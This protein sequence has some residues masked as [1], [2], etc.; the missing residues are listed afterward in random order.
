MCKVEE[1]IQFFIGRQKESKQL[2]RLFTDTLEHGS[3]MVLIAGDTG[4]GKSSLLHQLEEN[5][6]AR[7]GYYLVCKSGPLGSSYPYHPLAELIRIFMQRVGQN[8]AKEIISRYSPR[9]L[10]E[11][12]LLVPKFARFL[13]NGFKAYSL[14]TENLPDKLFMENACSIVREM[15]QNTPVV[16]IIE[17]IPYADPTTLEVIK[18]FIQHEDDFRI[19]ICGTYDLDDIDL[20]D[21]RFTSFR[22]FVRT[23]N[24]EDGIAKIN[25]KAFN[26]EEC[27]QLLVYMLKQE[28]LP[29]GLLDI[30]FSKSEGNPLVI[31]HLVGKLVSTKSLCCENNLWTFNRPREL[32]LPEEIKEMYMIRLQALK[33]ETRS[34]LATAAVIGRRFTAKSLTVLLEIPLIEVIPFLEDA[35]SLRLIEE[36]RDGGQHYFSFVSSRLHEVLYES[37]SYQRKIL[38]HEKIGVFLEQTLDPR[39]NPDEFAYHFQWGADKVKAVKYAIMAGQRALSLFAYHSAWAYFTSARDLLVLLD[40]TYM[41]QYRYE[42]LEGLAESASVL[43]YYTDAW[44]YLGELLGTGV[45]KGTFEYSSVQVK[46]G[47][48]CSRMGSFNEGLEHYSLAL[49]NCRDEYKGIIMNKIIYLYLEMGK[50][51]EAQTLAEMQLNRAEAEGEKAL[52][53]EIHIIFTL[54]Y[55]YSG[56]ITKAKE[57]AGQLC[58]Q[59]RSNDL[60]ELYINFS[61]GRLAI[62]TGPLAEAERLLQTALGLAQQMQDPLLSGQAQTFLVRV[63]ILKGHFA[64]A[65]E[66]LERVK[67][68]EV[69]PYS[70]LLREST[71]CQEALLLL[72]GESEAEAGKLRSE[73]REVGKVKTGTTLE[74]EILAQQAELAA[75]EGEEEECTVLLRK[76]GDL[77]V[78]HPTLRNKVRVLRAQAVYQTYFRE[79]EKAKVKN[80][81]KQIMETCS[82]NSL[83]GEGMQAA[84]IWPEFVEEPYKEKL[85][86]G[87]GV[88]VHECQQNSVISMP[89]DI[90][91]VEV[92][93]VLEYIHSQYA[94]DLN[95]PNLCH[96]ANLSERQLRRLFAQYM[97]VSIKEYINSYRI[98]RAKELL[99]N[100]TLGINQVGGL[101]GMSDKSH[102]CRV[103]KAQVGVSPT[104]F[105][106]MNLSDVRK[107]QQILQ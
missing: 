94:T 52:L 18:Y 89:H 79:G 75:V 107:R 1:N 92:A 57:Q 78:A 37:I 6:T 38:L 39:L 72:L 4:I 91:P 54:L 73:L 15:V 77:A 22:N 20:A 25:L 51:E 19:L 14:V 100:S 43:G 85:E 31:R 102:F 74:A 34:V 17:D 98:E 32:T 28:I 95:V 48:L 50:L 21:T 71:Y 23:L 10:N 82:K 9:V 24:Y 55:F 7:G 86:L 35:I 106:K 27:E 13:G 36:H 60:A 2:G 62:E 33:S 97:G 45:V 69:F 103:F 11:L 96:V 5:V 64:K 16:L 105:R 80:L 93:A 46:L 87:L 70:R 99:H 68:L 90:L 63:N 67:S 47:D 59:S 84:L 101:V 41:Q 56:E 12:S 76:V 58:L 53:H 88:E 81:V 8:Q 83:Q 29:A 104:E 42:V 49:E 44:K 65:R 66:I 3:R 40:K 61:L 30:V 26:R